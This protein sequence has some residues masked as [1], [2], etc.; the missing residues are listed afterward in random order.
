[1]SKS[2]KLLIVI[3]LCLG[4]LG[5]AFGNQTIDAKVSKTKVKTGEIFTYKIRV[6]GNFSKPRVILPE[7]K[8][9][10]IASHKQSKSYT[11][12]KGKAHLEFSM[13]YF[14]FA[15]KPGVFVIK[16]VIVEDEQ[17][18]YKSRAIKIKAIGRPLE[19]KKK[20]LPYIKEGT[21]I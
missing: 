5:L 20:I 16:P 7:F 21:S 3:F 15:D 17:K 9:F 10:K 14:L 18:K 13:T 8:D 2:F 1:M 6:E 11:I 12:R 19:E 4:S